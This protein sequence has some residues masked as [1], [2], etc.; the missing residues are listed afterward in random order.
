MLER[1]AIPVEE[2]AEPWAQPRAW[3]TKMGHTGIVELPG[4]PR[5][6]Q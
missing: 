1:G 3:A 5:V 6:P 2:G 4:G